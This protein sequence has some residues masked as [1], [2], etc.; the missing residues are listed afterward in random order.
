MESG[1]I[2]KAKTEKGS[3][4]EKKVDKRRKTQTV[5]MVNLVN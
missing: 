2:T 3:E 4:R 1:Q 5:E